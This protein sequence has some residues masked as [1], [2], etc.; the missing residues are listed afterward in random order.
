MMNYPHVAI[1]IINWNGWE[2]TI[3][4]LESVF[5]IN[6]PNFDVIVVDN[7]SED[8]SLEKIRKYC[9]GDLKVESDFFKYNTDNKPINLTEC[10]EKFDN[11]EFQLKKEIPD[12]NQI[13]LIKNDEN[14]G[15]P[16]GNNTGMKFALKFFNP[17]YILLL[18]NDTVV[19]ENFLGELIENGESKEDVGILGPKIYF[20]D[21]PDTIWSAGCKISWKLS[22]GIQIGTNEEDKGQY[23]TIKEVEYVS[24]SAFLVKTEVIRRI[25]LM[26]EKYFL[27]F[28]ESDWTVR[29]NQE[30]YKS[31]YIP[32]ANLW[33][34]VSKSG[35]GISNPI[36]LYYITRNRWIFM[37]KWAKKS[38]YG[39]F[40][41]YQ[42][43]GALVI[44]LGLSVYYRNLNLFIAY[45][46]G[47]WNGI[48]NL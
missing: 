27:Y 39:V 46:K 31:L 4:C 19:E 33:H 32:Q 10:N 36:G 29:A 25:G 23:D 41:V 40:I 20:Y 6:Y 7:A 17:D 15:F 9:S 22:R 30:G 5:Q 13:I 24:G 28:E 8:D 34:K 11:M 35:G 42:F 38:D 3:E 26:D 48:K 44:P 14:I 16:G 43:F 12:S 47:L 18:N 21:D 2:D 45:Y 1:V 37:N